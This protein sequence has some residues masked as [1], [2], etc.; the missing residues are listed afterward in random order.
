MR[1]PEDTSQGIA[2]DVPARIKILAFASLALSVAV[3]VYAVR[4]WTLWGMCPV[5]R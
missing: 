1:G 5:T 3:V 2:G 4:L